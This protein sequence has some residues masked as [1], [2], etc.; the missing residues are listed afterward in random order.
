M[1]TWYW[2]VLVAYILAHTGTAWLSIWHDLAAVQAGTSPSLSRQVKVE[3][4]PFVL[5][6]PDSIRA[7]DLDDLDFEK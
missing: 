7:W 2:Y 4:H 6:D 3:D 1:Q 5:Q